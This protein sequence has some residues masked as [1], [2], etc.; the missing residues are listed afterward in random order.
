MSRRVLDMDTDRYIRIQG[1]RQHN[2]R[3][4]SLDIP[5]DRLVVITGLSGSGK[6]SLA[7]DTIHAEG[8]RKYIETLSAYARQFVEQM[9]KPDVEHIE[10]LPPTIAIEQRAG[11]TSPRSTVATTTEVYDYLRLLYARVG[12]PHC[13]VCG[14]RI[15]RQEPSQ[16]VD[17]VLAWP[18][19]TRI[20]VLAPLLGQRRPGAAAPVSRIAAIHA[21]RTREGQSPIPADAQAKSPAAAAQEMLKRVQ[22]QGFVRV[23]VNGALYDL[24]DVPALRKGRKNTIDVVVDRLAVK[25]DVRSRL[26]E[27]IT[28]GLNLG[29]QTVFVAEERPGGKWRDHPFSTRFACPLHPEVSIPALSPVMFSFNSPHGACPGCDGLGNIL[30]FD[31]D[32]VVPDPALALADGAITAWRHSGKRMNV[33]YRNLLD[34]FCLRFH[35]PPDTPFDKLPADRR[36]IL[37]NGTTPHS[38]AQYDTRFEGVLPNLKRRWASTESE[39]LKQRLHAYLSERPCETCH[40]AR[41]RAEPLA[42]RVADKNI[43]QVAGLSV[44]QAAA[45]FTTISLTGE[46]AT[47][48][49]PILRAVT[50]RLRFMIDV[51]VGYLTLDRASATLSGG[52]AQRIRLATQVGSGMVGV[53]YVLDEPTIG[54]HPRDSSQ[55]IGTLRQL[56]NAGNTAIVVE[57]DE[58]TIRAADHVIDMG[59]GAGTHGGL[60]V[61]QGRLEQLLAHPDSLTARYLRGEIEIPVPQKRRKIV[62]AQSIEV[63]GA[64]E[65]NLKSIDVRFPLGGIIC[66][67]GVSGSGK[68]TLVNEVFLKAVRRR[69][70]NSRERPGKCEQIIGV[71]RVD[72]VI[73]IDQSPIGRTPRSNPCTYTGAFDLVRQLFAKTRESKIRGYS[74]GRFS[75]NVEGGRCEACQGQGTKRIEMHFLPDVYVACDVCKGTRYNRETL[76]VRYRGRNIADVL[77]LTVDDSIS[78]F[79]SFANI[80]QIAL[81]L[82][83]VGLSYMKLG[84]ASTTLSGGEAQRVKLAAELAKTPTGHTLYVLDEPTTGLHFAD[85][86]NLLRVLNRLADKGHTILV[87]EHNLEVIKMADW[88]IDLGPEGGEKG[89]RIVV[90]GRPEDVARNQNSYTGRFL[91]SRLGMAGPG[92]HAAAQGR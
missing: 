58:E 4:I 13:W 47:I 33:V 14:R 53:C 85:V 31:P 63:K 38:E 51:G 78:F 79:E 25:P 1:A 88:I 81:A 17:Q 46:K 39:S 26:A 87:I 80:R 34:E 10:G 16:I 73:E 23:R 35:V 69:L 89:G 55:L 76:E 50:D 41:L 54:L 45:F 9:Q 28:L 84:Q 60:I 65:N 5:R 40:G 71:S 44:E 57:H 61:A 72:R 2:L 59:P 92:P 67:T 86:D 3:G 48:A 64:A 66:V 32:L 37:M 70:Y 24:R 42:V 18:G 82:D 91:R 20:M 22:K 75:F 7:F 19:G 30:E 8:R 12:E 11:S 15:D 68:S 56:V 36:D 49:A 6:S 43:A 21:K 52:E 77:D 27:S 62:L 29:D 83:D 90:E 74:P